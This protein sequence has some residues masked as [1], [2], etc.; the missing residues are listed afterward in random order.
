[1]PMV[2]PQPVASCPSPCPGRRR[3]GSSPAQR[4]ARMRRF[5][6][7]AGSRSRARKL[8]RDPVLPF[9]RPSRLAALLSGGVVQLPVVVVELE[10]DLVAGRVQLPALV[11]GDV[12]LEE[13]DLAVAPFLEVGA[14]PIHDLGD[15]DHRLAAA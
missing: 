6:A 1:M 5:S 10:V 13:I 15:V 11:S 2:A 3:A 14:D 7:V 4:S 8:L 12:T 9:I